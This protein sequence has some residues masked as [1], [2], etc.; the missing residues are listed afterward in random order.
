[1]V[2]IVYNPV[3]GS[4]L[5]QREQKQINVVVPNT[6]KFI[7][8]YLKK[9]NIDFDWIDTNTDNTPE[10]FDSISNKKYKRILVCGGDG[11]VREVAEHLI[12][13][14]N[15][16]PLAIV[17]IGTMNVIAMSL[18]MPLTLKRALRYALKH[19]SAS[20]DVG[21]VNNEKYFFIACGAGYDAQFLAATGRGTKH[22]LGPLS[23]PL[24]AMSKIFNHDK[25][26]GTL[27]TD[28]GTEE[29][30][31]STFVAF[32][33]KTLVK[34]HP[35]LRLRPHPGIVDVLIADDITP[36]N[37]TRLAWYMFW[38][39]TS[40]T[41]PV[42][43]FTSKSVS[44]TSKKPISYEVDGDVFEATNIEISLVPNALQLVCQK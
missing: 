15:P 7:Q 27:K 1:M 44:F 41:P 37:A 31:S 4:M 3:A 36:M 32:N 20:F 35:F 26:K 17:P 18:N 22:W 23:Y 40:T 28:Q 11:T 43:L 25:I 42:R 33:I 13:Q 16:T 19:E 14:Q 5:T 24:I 29:L 39:K 9:E 38:R 2:L 6:K 8:L 34:H 10:I 12:K 21:V 30:N